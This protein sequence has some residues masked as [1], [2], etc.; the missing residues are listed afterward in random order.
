MIQDRDVSVFTLVKMNRPEWGWL[1]FGLFACVV[2]GAV[3]PAYAF[4]YGE[5][6]AVSI[7]YLEYSSLTFNW[8]LVK[9]LATTERIN[10]FQI[11]FGQ[12]L[13]Q[14]LFFNNEKDEG[15]LQV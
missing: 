12:I 6:F 8:T 9:V 3:T 7:D 5:V 10:Y 2:N 11:M 13:V 15:P 4:F 14:V 1:F